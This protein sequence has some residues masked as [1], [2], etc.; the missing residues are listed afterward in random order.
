[1]GPGGPLL[2]PQE[3][4]TELYSKPALSLSSR[5]R[6]T[7]GLFLLGLATKIL[8]CISSPP[9]DLHVTPISRSFKTLCTPLFSG[10]LAVAATHP[11][12]L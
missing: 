4:A 5:L 11:T 8:Y 6:L 10:R 1:M 3:S 12:C 9:C 7:R 2:F